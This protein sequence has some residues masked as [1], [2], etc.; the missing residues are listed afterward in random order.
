M[1]LIVAYSRPHVLRLARISG[2]G[3]RR[4]QLSFWTCLQGRWTDNLRICYLDMPAALPVTLDPR[5]RVV[6][7]FS[8]PVVCLAAA[9]V[10]SIGSTIGLDESS[11]G[12]YQ[13]G[14]ADA[15]WA[16]TYIKAFYLLNF[17][18]MYYIMLRGYFKAAHRILADGRWAACLM[19]LFQVYSTI[20]S[21]KKGIF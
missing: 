16:T 3:S 12:C 11:L 14:L 4:S 21:I 15:R 6:H 10:G 20:F 1:T 8:S 19:N 18:F 9:Q 5:H 2:H 17:S 13:N 7:V